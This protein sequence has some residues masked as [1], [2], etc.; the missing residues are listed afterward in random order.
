MAVQTAELK[1]SLPLSPRSGFWE[2]L[3]KNRIGVVGMI[4][5]VAIVLVAV[6]APLL[7]PYDPKSSEGITSSDVYNPP[8]AKHWLGTDDAGRDN[9]VLSTAHGLSHR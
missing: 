2:T 4:M 1:P 5:L 7:A 9:L 8:G 3:S 6:F